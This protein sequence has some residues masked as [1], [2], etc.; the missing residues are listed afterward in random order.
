MRKT[1]EKDRC[2]EVKY[3]AIM[4]I[5]RYLL[6]HSLGKQQLNRAA[7][8]S[9]LVR[10]PPQEQP[11]QIIM[12]MLWEKRKRTR[13]KERR[14]ADEGSQNRQEECNMDIHFLILIIQWKIIWLKIK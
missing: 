6:R 11:F 5:Q 14:V 4:G 10:S 12:A 1:R 3:N 13:V 9:R 7:A 2:G 8:Y